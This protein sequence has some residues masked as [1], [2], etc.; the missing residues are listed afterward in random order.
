VPAVRRGKIVIAGRR[1]VIGDRDCRRRNRLSSK[2]ASLRCL[3]KERAA[4]W[5]LRARQP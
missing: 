5:R 4:W 2:R 1:A 3:R